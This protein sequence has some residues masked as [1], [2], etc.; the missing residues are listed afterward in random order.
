MNTVLNNY[1]WPQRSKM[2]SLS[3]E[4]RDVL[5]NVSD[6]GAPIS[7]NTL[8]TLV[9][10]H[11]NTLRG[12]LDTLID[13][14]LIARERAPIRGRGRPSWLYR[15]TPASRQGQEYAGLAAVLADQMERTTEQPQAEA[16]AAGERWGQDLAESVPPADD[17]LDQVV[18]LLDELGFS[19]DRLED[20]VR[21]RSC[22]MLDVAKQHP[23]VVCG[24]HL[25]MVRGILKTAG[26]DPERA[27]L[28]AFYDPDACH[29]RLAR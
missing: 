5:D 28:L 4:C 8:S 26:A 7:V 17:V 20:R 25:G 15:P 3:K 21:L 14:G 6:H 13:L 1:P 24:V 16:I 23:D 29:I 10:T 2:E 27:E 9:G 22:P 11:P 12:H 19:P 18:T